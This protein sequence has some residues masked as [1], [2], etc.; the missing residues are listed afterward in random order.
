MQPLQSDQVRDLSFREW[1]A[2]SARAVVFLVHGLGSHGGRWDCLATFLQQQGITSYAIELN[3]FG[4]TTAL[5]GH[6]DSFREYYDDL[7]RLS[8]IGRQKYPAAPQFLAGESM[9]A[10]IGYVFVKSRPQLFKGLICVAPAF[11]SLIR[12]S[13]WRY[14]QIFG[15]L[16]IHR[17]RQFLMPFSA[18]ACT[19][20]P[21]YQAII[22]RDLEHNSVATAALLFTILKAQLRI[23]WQYQHLRVP[24]LFVVPQADPVVDNA[25]TR[26][27]FQRLK[28]LDKTLLSYPD[29]LHVPC[30]D[31]GKEKV[32]ED[33]MNWMIR[34][35]KIDN[36]L[37]L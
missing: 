33:I 9:G 20:D 28:C 24:V 19:R 27:V 35:L 6:A 22:K 31:I 10:L 12:F 2:A 4:Q 29:M 17:K 16:V 23:T 13:L 32:F 1:P 37:K 3:G 21:A 14:M 25:A 11:K 5:K 34:R 15:A 36:G 18:Q 7:Q 26:R 8:E 30:V